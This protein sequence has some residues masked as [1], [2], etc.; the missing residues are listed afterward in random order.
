MLMIHAT[1]LLRTGQF[2]GII[3]IIYV[4]LGIPFLPS[5]IWP[6]IAG[7]ALF[8]AGIAGLLKETV[9]SVIATSIIT[10]LLFV[11]FIPSLIPPDPAEIAFRDSLP[12]PPV[13]DAEVMI[14]MLPNPPPKRTLIEYPLEALFLGT[15]PLTYLLP[16]P[17][18][19]VIPEKVIYARLVGIPY[20]FAVIGIIAGMTQKRRQKQSP[21]ITV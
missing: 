18:E 15:V 9:C 3:A 7:S 13:E 5:G 6:F 14:P 8:F 19:G 4:V 10:M 17:Q 16:E 12:V 21:S 2:F 1:A 20:L 11:F